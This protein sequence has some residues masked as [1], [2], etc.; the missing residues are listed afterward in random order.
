MPQRAGS[1]Y[2][3]LPAGLLARGESVPGSVIL[4][5]GACTDA[6]GTV[7]DIQRML[8]RSSAHLAANVYMQAIPESVKQSVKSLNLLLFGWLEKGHGQTSRPN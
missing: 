1:I 8:R 2:Q 3:G 4:E 5:E 6:G 7:K